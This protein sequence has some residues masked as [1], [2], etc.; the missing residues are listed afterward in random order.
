MTGDISGYLINE[1][2]KLDSTDNLTVVVIALNGLK[3]FYNNSEIILNTA[4]TAQQ[5]NKTQKQIIISQKTEDLKDNE[6]EVN[7]DDA[8]TNGVPG[9]Y[10]QAT[11]TTESIAPLVQSIVQYGISLMSRKDQ[12]K[13]KA[14]AQRTKSL[15][16]TPPNQTV[17][18]KTGIITL[19]DDDPRVTISYKGKIC[20]RDRQREEAI[21]L[22]KE[23]DDFLTHSI[24]EDAL[25]NKC[26]SPFHLDTKYNG[27]CGKTGLDKYATEIQMRKGKDNITTIGV[28]HY[29]S[30]DSPDLV[31]GGLIRSIEAQGQATL[32]RLIEAQGQAT[33]NGSNYNC[34]KD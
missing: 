25:K 15:S 31:R 33:L 7:F 11:M 2:L 28:V 16:P 18:A 14:E 26:H 32:I 23:N 1:V 22:I 5:S 6:I 19:K 24:I 21:A 34:K 30:S 4:N 10:A 17:I 9:A 3:C 12:E 20:G 27:K 13:A 8:G 29:T